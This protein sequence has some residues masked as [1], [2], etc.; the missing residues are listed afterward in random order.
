MPNLPGSIALFCRKKVKERRADLSSIVL[1]YFT[2]K[3]SIFEEMGNKFV[4]DLFDI[5][6]MRGDLDK[7]QPLSSEK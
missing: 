4:D 6:K 7:G 5:Q 3:R 2:L 1:M